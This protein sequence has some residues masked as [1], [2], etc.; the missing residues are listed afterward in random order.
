MGRTYSDAVTVGTPMRGSHVR[1]LRDYIE[2]DLNAASVSFTWSWSNWSAGQDS[3]ISI[4]AVY[5]K[6]MRD[7]IQELWDSKGRGNLPGWTQEEPRGA[8]TGSSDPARIRASHVTDLRLWLNQYE[9]NHPPMTQ[10]INSHAYDPFTFNGPVIS[11][12]DPNDWT[13]D[14]KRLSS[15]DRRLFVR[16]NVWRRR[17]PGNPA[18][19]TNFDPPDSDPSGNPGDMAIYH[20]AYSQYE[21]RI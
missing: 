17:D 3:T 9:N 10:G 18:F 4:R 8:S 12:R 6:E 7:A 5:F 2:Q 1:T 21:I 14:V 11:D 19:T 13:S 16:L 20:L 15:D